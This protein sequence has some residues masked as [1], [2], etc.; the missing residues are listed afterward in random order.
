MGMVLGVAPVGKAFV[1]DFTVQ[2]SDGAG[3]SAT[4][5]FGGGITY[6]GSASGP[7]A[8]ST[9]NTPPSILTDTTSS[10]ITIGTITVSS[11]IARVFASGLTNTT[12]TASGIAGDVL[13]ITT[14]ES[15]YTTGAGGARLSTSA[16]LN[17]HPGNTGSFTHETAS[18]RNQPVPALFRKGVNDGNW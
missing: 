8:A 1:G 11:V 7:A 10:T 9:A 6:I 13:T 5:L 15:G 4:I 12:V 2:L 16:S 17:S 3:D 14:A 18:R